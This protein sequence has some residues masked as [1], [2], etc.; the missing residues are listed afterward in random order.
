MKCGQSFEIIY[1]R[2]RLLKT[3]LI[4]LTMYSVLGMTGTA[5]GIPVDCVKI[6]NE[7]AK[8]AQNNK[9]YPA[10]YS[11]LLK[12]I[13]ESLAVQNQLAFITPETRDWLLGA[14]KHMD[15]L[16]GVEIPSTS[17]IQFFELLRKLNSEKEPSAQATVLAITQ[18]S[19]QAATTT[20]DSE[21]EI[22]DDLEITDTNGILKTVKQ[23]KD[24][25][26]VIYLDFNSSSIAEDDAKTEYEVARLPDWTPTIRQVMKKDSGE[27]A[28]SS[29]RRN[30]RILKKIQESNSV[31]NITGIVKP[32]HIGKDLYLP[33]YE[34]NLL[35]TLN[36]KSEAKIPKEFRR[37]TIKRL[38]RTLYELH[39]QG[40]C[41]GDL[42][43]K[44]ILINRGEGGTTL[45]DMALSGFEN[46]YEPGSTVTTENT[47]PLNKLDP[48]YSAPELLE[49]APLVSNEKGKNICKEDV[50][51]LA[52]ITYGIIHNE[53]APWLTCNVE[54]GH[55][56][57]VECRK[58]GLQDLLRFLRNPSQISKN[59]AINLLLAAALDP[60][61]N[62]RINS[63]EFMK[64]IEN[65]VDP[66]AALPTNVD[67]KSKNIYKD[68]DSQSDN[69]EIEMDEDDEEAK[70]SYSVL[71]NFLGTALTWYRD[72]VIFL[73]KLN[74]NDE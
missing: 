18:D 43:P 26:G 36:R 39:T 49:N 24:E 7:I 51:A 46:A 60:N 8:V 17:M 4:A 28:Y 41:V 66:A 1:S 44:N 57:F 6:E 74:Q 29:F 47:H 72:G 59:Q 31:N 33:R 67:Q 20:G 62:T 3:F 52:T 11:E 14:A 64:G 23:N 61:P 73:K 58:Q 21:W 63:E 69:E 70:K 65:S 34:S 45:K 22:V 15:K 9:D 32:L 10:K 53:N 19:G 50:F 42:D 12:L 16:L 37:E 54:N 68:T 2:I 48:F 56:W 25:N 13:P 38:A 5:F 71:G 27:S 55:K 40:I 30:Q 35:K